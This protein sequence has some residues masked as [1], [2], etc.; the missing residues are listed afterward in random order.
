MRRFLTA[1]AICMLCAC[2]ALTALACGEQPTDNDATENSVNRT[3]TDSAGGN[4]IVQFRFST[5]DVITVELYPDQA[6]ISV[7]NFLTYV[8]EGYYTGTVIHRV[9]NYVVQG[10]GFV[11]KNY[12]YTQQGGTHEAIKGEFASNG[13]ANS[14]SHTAGA[15]SMARTT[16]PDSATSQFF[17]CPVDMSKSWD[18]SY[19]AF[20][21]VTDQASLDAIVRLSQTE[22]IEGSTYPASAI[23][24]MSVTVVSQ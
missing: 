22:T 4:P 6:P 1:L 17:F 18:G 5:G 19:A 14:V 13:V 10:G 12:T 24:V 23:T 8:N 2:V 11:I 20:G 15:I 3:D 7:A 9:E 21:H 16:A